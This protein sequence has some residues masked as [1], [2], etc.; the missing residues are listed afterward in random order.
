M[1]RVCSFTSLLVENFFDP[2][3]ELILATLR[4]A[5]GVLYSWLDRL[6]HFVSVGM[7]DWISAIDKCG[8]ITLL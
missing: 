2:A 7:N 1:S 3:V 6:A 8:L 5:A 4:L